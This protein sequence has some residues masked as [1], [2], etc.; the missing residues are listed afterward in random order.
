M[1]V[2][3]G[4]F[5]VIRLLSPYP[6]VLSP[7]LIGGVWRSSLAQHRGG[8]SAQSVSVTRKAGLTSCVPARPRPPAAARPGRA[9]CLLCAW[10]SPPSVYSA[11]GQDPVPWPLVSPRLRFR[12]NTGTVGLTTPALGTAASQA[13]L[14]DGVRLVG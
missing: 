1:G 9:S 13:V 3:Q 5:K 7:L 6:P 2:S 8:G 14:L 10:R 11:L 4:F 12:P